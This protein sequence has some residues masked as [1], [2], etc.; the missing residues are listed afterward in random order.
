MHC[1]ACID[2]TSLILRNLIF[3]FDVLSVSLD[4]FVTIEMCVDLDQVSD[5]F[6]RVEELI[7]LHYYDPAH[8]W[9]A[10]CMSA[11]SICHW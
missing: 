9:Y 8:W 4:L 5:L 6:V 1:S 3:R 11:V 2:F 10:G 7:F